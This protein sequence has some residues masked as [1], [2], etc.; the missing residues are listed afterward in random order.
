MVSKG[1]VLGN[2]ADMVGVEVRIAQIL[3]DRLLN[4]SGNYELAPAHY[5]VLSVIHHNPGINQSN[6]ARCMYLDRS[7]MVP[8]LNRLE[9]RD[10]IRRERD[11][12]D[13]RAHC[14]FLTEHGRNVLQ[15]ADKKITALEKAISER[16]GKKNRDQ[17]LKLL[18]QFQ[19]VLQQ[20][21]DLI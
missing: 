16:M 8:I 17:F 13:S 3:A 1:I 11:P 9:Q 2:L 15:R 4:S 6:L 20:E 5:M 14:V 7:S 21:Q 19:L 10:L 12:V 18:K